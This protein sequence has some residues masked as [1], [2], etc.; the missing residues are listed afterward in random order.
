MQMNSHGDRNFLEFNFGNDQTGLRGQPWS[1]QVGFGFA[2]FLLGEVASASQRVQSDLYGRRNYVALFAQ[3]DFRVND[4]LTMNLG[5]RWETTGGGARSTGAGATST[6]TRRTRCR[7]CPACSSSPTRSDGSFEGDREWTEFGPRAG[8]AYKLTR[9]AVF[10]SAYGFF[11]MRRR[12]GLLG[13]RALQ[14]RARALRH[15][16]GDAPPATARPAFN[17]NNGYPG[18]EV[19]AVKNPADNRWGLVSINPNALQAGRVQQWNAGVDYELTRD[20]VVGVNYLGNKGHECR[21]ATSSA[22]SPIPRRM[23]ALL[24]GGPSG[25]GCPTRRR[26]PPP[27]CRIPMPA[28][29]FAFFALMPYVQAAEGWGPLFFVGSPLGSSDYHALQL[30]AEKRMSNGVA[31][32]AYTLSRARGNMDSGSRSAGGSARSRTSRSSDEEAARHRRQRP[33]ARAQGLRGLGA[34]VGSGRRFMSNANTVVDAIAGGWTLSAIFRYQSGQP[35]RILSR[36]SYTGWS[37][38]GYPIYANADPNGNFDRQFNAGNFDQANPR[39]RATA[40]STHAP[41]RTRRTGSS[42]RGP[43]TSSSCAASAAPTKTSGS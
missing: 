33:D 19:P 7:P 17:W 13:R 42:G 3:D 39:R 23:K 8:L 37:T 29:N 27:A 4:R 28:S 41:S 26:P 38:F 30:T 5:L 24:H 40:T 15:E 9:R 20:L 1:N 36:N 6:S 22:T 10:R 12:R 16:R 25:T 35:L 21:A 34:A 43:G 31:A 18:S 2:S 14:L 11:Y 32:A